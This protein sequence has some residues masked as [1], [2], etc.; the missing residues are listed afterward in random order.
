MSLTLP[1][2]SDQWYTTAEACSILGIHKSTMQ[3]WHRQ[4]LAPKSF[5][6][7]R[8]RL[9]PLSELTDWCRTQQGRADAGGQAVE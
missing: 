9:F 2:Q 7:G 8:D 5:L 1:D 6:L 3:K 4:G